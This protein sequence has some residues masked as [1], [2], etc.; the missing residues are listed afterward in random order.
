VDKKKMKALL[1]SCRRKPDRKKLERMLEGQRES[2]LRGWW[3][4]EK[5][6]K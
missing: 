5:K 1:K 2:Y 3:Q 4:V 6:L